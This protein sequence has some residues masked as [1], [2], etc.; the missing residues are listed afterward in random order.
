MSVKPIDLQTNIAQMH[1]VARGA[2]VR[3]EAVGEQQVLLDKESSEK[4]RLVSSRVDQNKKA[5]KTI[6]MD[7]EKK[8]SRREHK[9]R[10]GERREKKEEQTKPLADDRMGRII[11]VKK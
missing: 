9:G 6:I 11:D 3:S 4:S 2:Q 10:E 1:E 5:E 7:E 8:H